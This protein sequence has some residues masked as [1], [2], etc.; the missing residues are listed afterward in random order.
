[1]DEAVAAG[2]AVVIDK[3]VDL[4]DVAS[5]LEGN[6]QAV[7][8]RSVGPE[9]AELAGNV[10]GSRERIALALGCKP[11]ALSHEIMRRL[12]NKP[13]I[14]ELT[15]AEAPVQQVV[16]TGADAD[17]TKLPVHLQHARSTARRI[18]R[19]PSTSCVIQPP[20]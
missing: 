11:E 17:L 4:A 15:R 8:F 20:A 12:Q 1:M 2:Q 5:H 7:L 14:V 13:Q 6:E 16:L 19:P 10:M 3:P 18:S 9:G